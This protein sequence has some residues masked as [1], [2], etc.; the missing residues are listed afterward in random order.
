[1]S[2]TLYENK[3]TQD[4]HQEFS[5]LF[6][7]ILHAPNLLAFD[8]A[9][10]E[11]P[12]IIKIPKIRP[13]ITEIASQL[14]HRQ[15]TAKYYLSSGYQRDLASLAGVLKGYIRSSNPTLVINV[16]GKD[17]QDQSQRNS[18]RRCRHVAL[19]RLSETLARP[20]R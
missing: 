12:N 16:N 14:R 4:S 13:W 17:W 1:M 9:Q 10:R 2:T 15:P 8:L 7:D 19:A 6:L 11:S 20:L 5:V 3:N 18:A